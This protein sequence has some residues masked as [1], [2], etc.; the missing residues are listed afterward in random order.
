MLV[1]LVTQEVEI[2]RITVKRS[3]QAHSLRD[4][5]PKLLNIEKGWWNGSSGRCLELKPQ[6]C[7]KKKKVS[8][9]E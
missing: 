4:P 9:F 3:A 8:I 1:I 6:Y 2:R 7:Q 5:I